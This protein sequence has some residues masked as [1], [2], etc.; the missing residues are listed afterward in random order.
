MRLHPN[1]PPEVSLLGEVLGHEVWASWDYLLQRTLQSKHLRSSNSPVIGARVLR[2]VKNDEPT[3]TQSVV[4]S[5]HPA[6][7]P[8]ADCAMTANSDNFR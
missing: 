3:A 2:R 5:A 8:I 6:S 4:N 7:P 1:A